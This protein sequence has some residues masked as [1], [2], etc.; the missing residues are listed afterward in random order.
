M[1]DKKVAILIPF[2]IQDVLRRAQL[3]LS[4]C[5]ELDKIK[6]LLS[7]ND[8]ATFLAIQNTKYFKLITGSDQQD[9]LSWI[10][11]QGVI[12]SNVELNDFLWKTL[13]PVS[14]DSSFNTI[15]EDRLFKK[16]SYDS[17]YKEPFTIY[18]LTPEV[19][20]IVIYP[21]HFINSNNIVL[22][23]NTLE[24]ILDVLYAY[25]SFHEVAKSIFFR[26]YLEVLAKK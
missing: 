19:F 22:Q 5:L 12:K 4:A 8:L 3:P 13:I 16:E 21:G 23:K 24:A 26:S 18:D 7:L 25:Q 11:N 10:W 14:N 15:V 9:Q 17:N 6:P 20:G 2:W 1:G